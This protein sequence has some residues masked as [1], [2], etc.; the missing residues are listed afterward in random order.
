MKNLLHIIISGS[1]LLLTL[2]VNTSFAQKCGPGPHWIDNCPGGVDRMQTRAVVGVNTNTGTDTCTSPGTQEL[3]GP[4][5]VVRRPS[6]DTSVT[7]GCASA[8]TDIH[9]A[10]PTE[11]DS[12]VLTGGGYTLL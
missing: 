9:K 7:N 4:V 1:L 2:G 6:K 8:R 11:I 10:I 3:S 5:R 12:M